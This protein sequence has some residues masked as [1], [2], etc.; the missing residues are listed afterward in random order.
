MKNKQLAGILAIC[1]GGVG[2]HHFYLG[3]LFKGL[4]FL[5]LAFT[6]VGAFITI[7][8]SLIKGLSLLSMSDKSFDVQYNQQLLEYR[9]A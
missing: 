5:A 9:K 4:I 1:L 8:L 2:I 3:S 7:P 6:M